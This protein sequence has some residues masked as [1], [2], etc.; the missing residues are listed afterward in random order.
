[1]HC[2]VWRPQ[3]STAVLEKGGDMITEKIILNEE[4]NVTLTTYLQPVGEEFAHIKARP[5]I[6]VIPGGGYDF[7]S[8]REAEP[9]ALAYLRE[10]YQAFVLRYSVQQNKIWPTPLNDYDEAMALVR[11]R[12]EEWH[13]IPDK[14]AVIG[15][16]AGGH[17]AASAATMSVN[18]PNAAILIYAVLDEASA[19]EWNETAPDTVSAVDEKTCPCFVAA[20]RTD[21]MVPAANAIAFCDALYRNDI[22]FESHIYSYAP[23][24]F[25]LADNTV[26]QS[27]WKITERAKDWVRDSIG[28]L[29]EVFGDFGDSGMTEPMYGHYALLEH[30]DTLSVDASIG[31]IVSTEGGKAFFE[32]MMAQAAGAAGAGVTGG[33]GEIDLKQS[34]LARFKMRDLLG[35][36]GMSAETIAE[37]DAQLRNIPRK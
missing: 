32:T 20:S 31:Q 25:S 1:M 22:S 11:S 30:G 37:I 35:F 2:K 6:I 21:T 26:R 12:A 14:I 29:K 5:A 34:V 27:G 9:I 33:A 16:S 13:I 17:L 28:W 23:H 10:G 24:G 36:A 4:R 19:K 3:E 8:D 15:F 18:R 7:C